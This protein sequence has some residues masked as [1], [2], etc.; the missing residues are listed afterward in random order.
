VTCSNLSRPGCC[1]GDDGSGVI[2]LGDGW[3]VTDVLRVL[4][5]DESARPD[6]HKFV[7]RH[8][9]RWVMFDSS[10]GTAR[11]TELEIEAV[12]GQFA[13]QIARAS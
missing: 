11:S 10:D 2:N 7:F 9:G 8:D 5:D 6:E 1:W 12:P 4:G 3:I 13:V